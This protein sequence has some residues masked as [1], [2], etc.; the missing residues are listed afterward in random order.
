MERF[1]E[2]GPHANSPTFLVRTL[3]R[4]RYGAGT[5]PGLSGALVMAP[6]A[7]LAVPALRESLRRRV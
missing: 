1:I 4:V 7:I 6:I 5:E 3:K 2:G